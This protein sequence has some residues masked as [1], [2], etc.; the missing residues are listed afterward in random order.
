M[1][2]VSQGTRQE[3]P[4]IEFEQNLEHEWGFRHFQ[5]EHQKVDTSGGGNYYQNSCRSRFSGVYLIFEVFQD[6][7]HSNTE[8]RV[9]TGMLPCLFP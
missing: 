7:W 1:V 8:I 6:I 9:Y 3:N 4:W 5:K 2:S